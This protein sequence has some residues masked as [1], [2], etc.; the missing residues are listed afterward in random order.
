MWCSTWRPSLRWGDPQCWWSDSWS[1]GRKVN[2]CRIKTDIIIQSKSLCGDVALTLWKINDV[3][4]VKA[5]AAISQ[6]ILNTLYLSTATK[7]T[8]LR[9]H[10]LALW[11]LLEAMEVPVSGTRQQC[12]YLAVAKCI[13]VVDKKREGSPDVFTTETKVKGQSPARITSS[14]WSICK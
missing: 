6:W 13:R 3:D 7:E 8:M 10:L 11:S 9:L 4:L 2:C 5:S 12:F 14:L 1:E